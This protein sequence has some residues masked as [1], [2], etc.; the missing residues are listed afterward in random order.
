[1]LSLLGFSYI[2]FCLLALAMFAHHRDVLGYAPSEKRSRLLRFAGWLAIGVSY[3][4]A[5]SLQGFAYGSISYFGLLAAAGVLVVMTLS[6]RAKLMPYLMS[7]S[8]L[9]ST[10]LFITSF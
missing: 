8:A 9:L 4:G 5:V 2:A 1:M 10:V 7:L 3:W 6:Y